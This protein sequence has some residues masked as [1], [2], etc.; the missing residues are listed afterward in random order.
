M[1][2][3]L[4]LNCYDGRANLLASQ[5]YFV[6][7]EK[8]LHDIHNLGMI[9]FRGDK[10]SIQSDARYYVSPPDITSLIADTSIDNVL[11]KE[12]QPAVV[13]GYVPK[14]IKKFNNNYYGND[15]TDISSLNIW[16][17]HSPSNTYTNHDLGD[18]AVF[19]GQAIKFDDDQEQYNMFFGF[20]IKPIIRK[21]VSIDKENKVIII[22]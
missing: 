10:H 20:A 16:T 14:I 18:K 9:K 8:Y 13:Y 19:L 5:T 3:K 2:A 21:I 1:T 22:K 7:S 11:K 4:I 15:L 12:Y 6:S 17:I